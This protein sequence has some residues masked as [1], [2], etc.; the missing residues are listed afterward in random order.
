ML[1]THPKHDEEQYLELIRHI[2]EEGRFCE[3]RNGTT[4]GVVGAAMRFDLKDAVV[5]ILTTK[6]VAHKTCLKELLWFISG[7]TDNA[8][9][10]AQGVKIWN[11]NA[12]RAY[13]DSV[14]MSHRKENDLGPVYG[15]QWRH[16]NAPYTSCEEDYEG[17]GV[18]QLAWIIEQLQDPTTRHS[19][20]L[21]MSAWNP[22]QLEEMAL[23]PCH[24]L[25]QF[26][27]QPHDRLSCSLYQRS[28]DVGLGVPFNIASYALLTHLVAHHCDLEPDSFCYHL[29][30]CHI[31]E[32]HLNSLEE[33]A[34][35]TPLPFP[36]VRILTK[37]ERL[38]D[39]VVEDFV[40]EQYESYPPVLMEM[41]A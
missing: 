37:R 9:L 18:D 14:G 30:D 25:V 32:D 41:R 1:R 28:A 4:K 8:R 21:V 33:Q 27:V 2:L 5:P 13:L 40:V 15:H 11:G 7:S 26:H 19:R 3:G 36:T 29:G 34:T 22:C 23:P 6:R 12:S 31:Y 38:E 16:F 24:V 39:Y 20:R 17:Q 35:R 10:Q